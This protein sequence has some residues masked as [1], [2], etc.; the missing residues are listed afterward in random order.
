ML[1]NN[2]Q[3]NYLGQQAG[4]TLIELLVVMFIIGLLSTLIVAGYRGGQKRYTLEQ[5]TQKLVSDLRKTQNMA[6]SGGEIPGLCDLANSCNGYG[7]YLRQ[8]RDYYIIYGNKDGSKRYGSASDVILETIDLP[9]NIEIQNV[10]PG[11]RAHI[12]FE[13]PDPITYIDNNS[14]PGLSKAITLELEGTSLTRTITIT[15]AGLI[16]SN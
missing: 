6:I 4:F 11:S 12:C 2:I 14:S 5:A 15:T 1:K 8:N 3:K 16:Y 13:P 9:E 7:V 10:A